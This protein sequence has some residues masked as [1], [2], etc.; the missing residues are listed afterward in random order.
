LLHLLLDI[1]A[2]DQANAFAGVPNAVSVD[3][4]APR[5]QS[6][7]LQH[8]LATLWAAKGMAESALALWKN[9]LTAHPA[10]RGQDG[11]EESTEA[12]EGATALLKSPNSCPSELVLSHLPWLLEVSSDAA[13][14]VLSTREDLSPDDILPFLARSEDARWR[15]LEALVS[16]GRSSDPRLHTELALTLINAICRAEPDLQDPTLRSPPSPSFRG[17]PVAPDAFKSSGLTVAALVSE[18]VDPD[19]EHHA[20]TDANNNNNND[21]NTS[22]VVEALRLRLRRHLQT[23]TLWDQ[24]QVRTALEG[25]ALYEECAVA[26]AKAEDHHAVLRWLAIS[27]RDVDGAVAYAYAHLQST[28]HRILLKMLLDPESASDST[29]SPQWEAAAYVVATLGGSLDPLEIVAAVPG[30]MPLAAALPLVEPL[31]RERVHRRRQG[32]ITTALERSRL[33]SR[34]AGKVEAEARR[35]VVDE[36]RA[37]LDCHLRIGGKVFVAPPLVVPLADEVVA[38]MPPSAESGAR[39]V[40]LNCWNKRGAQVPSSSSSD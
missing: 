36:G 19:P 4:I 28:D 23:S 7:G 11:S 2:F 30:S 3:A 32:Q 13:H 9:M 26:A 12:L 33:A 6:L 8:A 34:T 10:S 17:R 18:R 5:L 16:S 38:M 25:T 27:L 35:V 15:Y 22:P 20:S 40:C 31:V 1:E 29:T 14:E 24:P 37:C 21:N 39:V